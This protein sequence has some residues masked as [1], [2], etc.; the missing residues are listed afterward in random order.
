MSFS[1]L[2]RLAVVVPALIASAFVLFLVYKFVQLNG[3]KISPSFG[4]VSA[5]TAGDLLE[6]GLDAN[7]VAKAFA[8]HWTVRSPPKKLPNGEEKRSEY[9]IE[10]VFAP[11]DT[12]HGTW[13]YDSGGNSGT[14]TIPQGRSYAE[15]DGTYRFP[16]REYP[17]KEVGEWLDTYIEKLTRNSCEVVRERN[18]RELLRYKATKP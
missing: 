12:N 13:R 10:Y 2:E 15:A 6:S 7:G 5:S 4:G 11:T 1:K 18:G 3:S 14:W 8:G 16:L 9:G 17:D